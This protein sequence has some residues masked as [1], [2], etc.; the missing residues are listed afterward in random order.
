MDSEM[1][2][3]KSNDGASI[4]GQA[5]SI[6]ETL[7]LMQGRTIRERRESQ[8][9]ATDY[10]AACV[11]GTVSYNVEICDISTTGA[12]VRI[13]RGVVPRQDQHISLRLMNGK[14]V[15]GV[16]VWSGESEIRVQ[17]KVPEPSLSEEMNFDELGSEFFSSVLRFQIVR[18]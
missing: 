4:S 5:E 15:D 3:K 11:L 2:N 18:E 10:N 16:V 12:R 14:V 7:E 13:R 17:F 1:R 6:P 9:F 8:R